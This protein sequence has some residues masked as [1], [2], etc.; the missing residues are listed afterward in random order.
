MTDARRLPLEGIRV[1]DFG[2]ILAGPFCARL[3]VDLGADV[4]KVETA[5]RQGSRRGAQLMK[6][7]APIVLS[8]INRNRR[9]IDLDLKSDVG[10]DIAQRLAAQADVLVENFSSGVM[11]RLGLGYDVLAANNPGLVYASMSAFGHTGPHKDWTGMN[12]TLQA[13]S[14]MMLATGE[15]GDPPTGISNSWNDYIGGLHTAVAIVGALNERRT[16]GRGRNLNM[17]QFECSAGM[18]GGPLLY[19][20]ITGAAPARAGNRSY[21]AAPQGVYRCAGTDEW[22]A[23]GIETDAQWQAL[24]GVL[25]DEAQELLRAEL[26]VPAGRVVHHDD[27]DAVIETWTRNLAPIEAENRLTAAGV[28][29]AAMRRGNEL[30]DVAEWRQVLHPIENAGGFDWQ[31]PGLPF[32]FAGV[33]PLTPVC[34]P[35]PGEH[36]DEVL[37]DWLGIDDPAS[38]GLVSRAAE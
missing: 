16:T 19:A 28:P 23:I 37:R 1:L 20:A 4:I 6:N 33:A 26:D 34:T 11:D 2:H 8:D 12:V 32:A 25:G 31:V 27:I 22:C 29:A 18:I 14:G 21:T 24:L 7:G 36:S 38:V 3:L 35:A 5:T 15:E 30:G 17:A 10:R 13:C 9:S